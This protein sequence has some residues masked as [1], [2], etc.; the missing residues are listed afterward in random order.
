MFVAQ[1]LPTPRAVTGRPAFSN[2]VLLPGILKVLRSG[3]RWRDLDDPEKPSDITHWR[4][5]RY[6]QGVGGFGSLFEFILNLLFELYI[7][8]PERVS[9]DGTLVPSY[10]FDELTSYSGKH[11]KVGTK[12]SLAVDSNGLPLGSLLA[13]G[14]AHDSPLAL[15]TIELIPDHIFESIKVVL[16]DKGYD[17]SY[18]RESLSRVG[19]STDIPERGGYITSHEKG[20]KGEEYVRKKLEK[21]E[22]QRLSNQAQRYVVERTN[23]WTKNFRRLHFRFDYTILSFNAFL[24]LALIVMLVRKL[25]P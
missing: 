22:Q 11:K 12:V 14:S 16:G 8:K 20:I 1:A 10:N 21:R 4:R 23:A 24:N 25:I 15:P 6:W 3:M 17:S 18:L 19:I 13:I 2:Y 5:L 7:L 9:I